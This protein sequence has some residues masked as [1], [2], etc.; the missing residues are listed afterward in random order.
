MVSWNEL[1]PLTGCRADEEAEQFKTSQVFDV[2]S[3]SAVIFFLLLR[4]TVLKVLAVLAVR[5]SIHPVTVGLLNHFNLFSRVIRL[6]SSP[7][8][9]KF[10]HACS[11]LLDLH[12]CIRILLSVS[13]F[14][15]SWIIQMSTQPA[16]SSQLLSLMS[17]DLCWFD[18]D[19]SVKVEERDVLPLLREKDQ[20]NKT[21]EN[22]LLYLN[23]SARLFLFIL[24]F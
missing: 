17:G 1:K 11:V 5:V 18:A 6:S 3:H 9:H 4:L 16:G 14:C 19:C 12:L 23:S 21:E 10:K 13:G 8:H 24:S 20:S 2:L 22:K 7:P 15:P